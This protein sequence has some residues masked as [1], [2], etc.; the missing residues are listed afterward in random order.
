MQLVDG[1]NSSPA[2]NF[3]IVNLLGM[4][5]LVVSSVELLPGASSALYG[6]NAFNGTL[7]MNS[8]NPFE[9]F[10][11]S[12]FV[13]AKVNARWVVDAQINYTV[14]RIKSTFK[15]GRANIGLHEYY[16]APGVGKI[17]SQ[18]YVSWT[19]NP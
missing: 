4:S 16:S 1:V 9:H 14:P 7:F 11:E 17:G 6:A 3:N 18:Y 10:W 8:K 13:D 19:L 12:S 5:E 2:L 15:T